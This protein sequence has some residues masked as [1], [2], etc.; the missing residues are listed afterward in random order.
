MESDGQGTQTVL[1]PA[2]IF[3][4]ERRV[5]TSAPPTLGEHTVAVLRDWLGYDDER[6][7][8]LGASGVLG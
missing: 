2:F 8:V 4:G 3:E 7:E 1:A 6:L 5:R